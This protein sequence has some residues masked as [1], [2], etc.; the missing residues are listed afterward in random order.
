MVQAGVHGHLFLNGGN[1]VALSGEGH[2]LHS[3][4]RDFTTAFRWTMVRVM[5]T[6]GPRLPND[7][8]FLLNGMLEFLGASPSYLVQPAFVCIA[9][10]GAGIIWPTRI[11]KMELNV[12]QVLSRQPLDQTRIGLQFGFVPLSY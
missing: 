9:A 1:L 10:Q 6:S 2:S 5:L 7:G 12:S 8:R 4:W 3:A 11:G